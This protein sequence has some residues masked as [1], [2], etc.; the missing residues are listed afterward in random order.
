MPSNE[1]IEWLAHRE[2]VK[3][4]EAADPLAGLARVR[5]RLEA[6]EAERVQLVRQR[7]EAVA[8]ARAA[9]ATWA[10]VTAAAGVA[11]TSLL[12]ADR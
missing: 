5:E 10:A 6:L 9:G 4:A 8:R 2:R 11:R 12:E 1:T 3:A 7:A